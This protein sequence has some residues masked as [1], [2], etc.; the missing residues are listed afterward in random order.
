MRRTSVISVLLGMSTDLTNFN[1]TVLNPEC[2]TLFAAQTN[3]VKLGV[4]IEKFVVSPTHQYC[5]F[6]WREAEMVY[7]VLER[8][9]RSLFSV[10]EP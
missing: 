1:L 9:E 10:I 6:L 3:L 5:C 4:L 7:G 2:H 8:I